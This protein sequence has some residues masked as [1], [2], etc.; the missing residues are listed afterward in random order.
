MWKTLI[1]AGSKNWKTT[2]AGIIGGL[3]IIL[4]ALQAFLDDDPNTIPDQ[5]AAIEAAVGIVVILWGFISR[6]ADKSSRESGVK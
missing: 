6:D 2:L 4:A 1:R 3:L 5:K